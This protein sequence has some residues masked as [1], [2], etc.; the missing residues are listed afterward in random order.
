[1]QNQTGTAGPPLAQRLRQTMG[2]HKKWFVAAL[3][4][5][6]GY[7][8]ANSFLSGGVAPFGVAFC[9]ALPGPH[10]AGA[11]LGAIVG[12]LVKAGPLSGM[13]YIAAILLVLAL[14]YLV[15]GKLRMRNQTAQAVLTAFL[16]LAVS[17]AA[18]FVTTNATMYEVIMGL[19][20]LFLCCGAAY[21]FQRALSC[22]ELGVMS[23]SRSDISCAIIS[24][25]IVMMGFA[26]FRIGG[27][28]VGRMVSVLVVLLCAR[29]GREAGGAVS[30][31]TAGI[32]MGL[33]G[34]DYAYVISAYGFGG[35]VAG[36]FGN[37]GSIPTA[38]A[39][40]VV[41]TVTAIFTK[42]GGNIYTG[43]FEIFV[44]SV[45]FVAMPKSWAQQLHFTQ[46]GRAGV[47]RDTSTQAALRDKMED[48]SHSLRDISSLTH[49]VSEKLGALG[50]TSPAAVYTRV[51][52]RVCH[53]CGMKTTC[54]QYRHG[55]TVAALNECM[56]RMKQEGSTNRARMPKHFVDTCCKLEDFIAELNTQFQSFVAEEGTQLKV[57][58][59]RSVVTDQFEGMAMMIDEISGELCAMKLQE[60]EKTRRVQEYFEK[61]G[62]HPEQLVC[63]TDEFERT[64]VEMVLP[65]YEEAKLGRI[66]S[67]LDLCAL[68]EVEFD[69][70]E[71]TK[72]EK[73][74]SVKYC[75]KAVYSVELGA[76][77][78]A[79]GKNRLCGDAYDYIRNRMGKTHLI[80]SDGMGSGG[81]AAVDSSMAAGLLK[82]M[83]QVGISH[84]AALKMVN[85]ALLIKSGEESLATID[86]C[87]LDL[88]TGAAEFYKAGAAPTYVIRAGKVWQV[89]S[90]SLPA[91]ILRG[92]SFEKN[93]AAL[94]EGD[95]V[96]LVSDGVT[97]TGCE[98]VISELESCRGED[99]QRL[100]ERL[101]AT[102]KIRRTDGREDDITVMA[103]ALRRGS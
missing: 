94:G 45:M 73:R 1:M 35:L 32:A 22:V 31:I 97:A 60:P 26:P 50:G 17:T 23:L 42:S 33:S 77:Q 99:V 65:G 57:G 19:A 24:C 46:L 93:S 25:A 70:P 62:I 95:V 76:Y 63:Y 86:V 47:V 103:A 98:W 75:E 96:V 64:S 48:V 78:I 28:S 9:A 54:W 91:G 10:A 41:N 66:K 85:S 40:V 87:S 3:C 2:A 102:A 88:F 29:Y 100:C 15:M 92:V 7:V 43:V 71:V 34:G 16:G 52:E 5:C 81:S 39:F 12:Y 21:F 18:V 89:E 59:V 51:A 80:L 68:L 11:A 101:A 53:Q 20:E 38:A 74:T 36:V 67:A 72:R 69:P 61:E 30:G 58:R 6:T 37:M 13:K 84:E 44:A 79:P 55:E 56:R 14:R 8:M 4:A 49:Q 27:L 82:R 83:I 90:T